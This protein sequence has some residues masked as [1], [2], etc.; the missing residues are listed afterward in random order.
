MG[1]YRF[2]GNVKGRSLQLIDEGGRGFIAGGSNFPSREWRGGWGYRFPQREGFFICPGGSLDFS[3][4]E[5]KKLFFGK[6]TDLVGS[7]R[8]KFSFCKFYSSEFH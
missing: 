7:G 5:W 1:G 4:E 2:S 8:E 3:L 6:R